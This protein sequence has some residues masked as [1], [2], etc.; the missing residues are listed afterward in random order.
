MAFSGGVD[1]T[2]LLSLALDELGPD[3]VLA[4]TAH[5]DV[6]TREELEAARESGRAAGGA[7]QWSP[8]PELAVPGFAAN[9]PERCYLCRRAMYGRLLEVAQSE[10]MTTVVDGANLDD[11]ATTAGDQAAADL[12][13][14]APWPKPG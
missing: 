12:G 6:H 4:V 7:T 1:S 10:G 13:S 11:R 8:Y 5:G 3:R 9:P 14:S 2:L